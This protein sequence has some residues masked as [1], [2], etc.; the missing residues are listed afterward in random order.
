MGV[1][2]SESWIMMVQCQIVQWSQSVG[3][4]EDMEDGTTKLYH[5]S[6]K[7][8]YDASIIDFDVSQNV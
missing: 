8:M 2:N 4:Y 6:T 5:V 1:M 3:H 7:A